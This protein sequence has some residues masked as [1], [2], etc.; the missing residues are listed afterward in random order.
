MPYN[1]EVSYSRDELI[2]D[3]LF[4]YHE[5]ANYGTIYSDNNYW[6]LL[7]GPYY[8]FFEEGEGEDFEEY[9]AELKREG[10]QYGVLKDPLDR[11]IRIGSVLLFISMLEAWPHTGHPFNTHPLPTYIRCLLHAYRRVR[12]VET[13]EERP[14]YAAALSLCA[15]LDESSQLPWFRVEKFSE[16]LQDEIL[17]E[18]LRAVIQ[19][20]QLGVTR[21]QVADI[22]HWLY[23]TYIRTYFLELSQR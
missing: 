19:E 23:T 18:E 9:I 22:E 16:V 15:F 1:R 2:R 21:E 8:E 5:C 10:N 14:V 13:S 12:T 11:V 3:I 17:L 6:T 7:R 20:D 4:L